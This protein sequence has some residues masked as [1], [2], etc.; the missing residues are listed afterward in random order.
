MGLQSPPQVQYDMCWY[1]SSKEGGRRPQFFTNKQDNGNDN[2]NTIVLGV[3]KS[4][5]ELPP[6]LTLQ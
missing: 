1:M 5:G 6:S 2:T 3:W 4:C